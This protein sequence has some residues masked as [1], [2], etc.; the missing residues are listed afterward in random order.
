[1][2]LQVRACC[3]SWTTSLC[4]A[5]GLLERQIEGPDSIACTVPPVPTSIKTKNKN[6]K[7]NKSSRN[8]SEQV[9]TNTNRTNTRNKNIIK[10][11][12]NRNIPKQGQ[13]VMAQVLT[14]ASGRQRQSYL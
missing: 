5:H 3:T 6:L 10:I 1:M 4:R 8:H 7:L 2:A 12:S 13:A 14:P 9:L 11:S